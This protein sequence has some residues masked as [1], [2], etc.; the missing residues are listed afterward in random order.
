MH[1]DSILLGKRLCQLGQF[2]R[3]KDVIDIKE[4]TLIVF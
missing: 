2:C 4:Q 3:F 1:E